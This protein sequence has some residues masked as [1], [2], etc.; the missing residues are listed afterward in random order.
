M[1]TES[2]L[3]VR[4]LKKTY[5]SGNIEL[6]VLSDVSFSVYPGEVIAL[7]GPSGVGKTTLLNLIG[8]LDLPDSGTISLKGQLLADLSQRKLAQVR[9][10]SLGFVFQ[11]HHLLPE[12]TALE[13]V[14]IPKMIHEAT[15]ERHHSRAK[16]L[17]ETF[18][19]EN[20]MEHYPHQLSGGERQRVALARALMNNPAL[21]LADEPTGNLDRKS[22][23]QLLQAILAFSQEHRQTFII[24]THDD[25]IAEQAQRILEIRDG[26]VSDIKN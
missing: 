11:F 17:L 25:S 9:N 10:T 16:K 20:R 5:R 19:L 4:H 7:M 3:E 14:L 15:S 12:F 1:S 23:Q 26:N 6:E 22:G 2:L 8:A 21:V 18:G 24:A 13:N